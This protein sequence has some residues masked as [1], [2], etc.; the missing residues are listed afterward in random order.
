MLIE[1]VSETEGRE[2]KSLV[3]SLPWSP[4]ESIRSEYNAMKKTIKN[5][6]IKD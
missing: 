5:E 3:L 4:A 1:K 2:I 6:N